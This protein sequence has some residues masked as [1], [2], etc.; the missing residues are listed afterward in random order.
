MWIADP[1]E[2]VTTTDDSRLV[3]AEWRILTPEWRT[4]TPGG[5]APISCAADRVVMLERIVD[6]AQLIAASFLAGLIALAHP[7][8]SPGSPPVIRAGRSGMLAGL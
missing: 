1:A 7:A 6:E 4:H 3:A 5:C 8:L 2:G